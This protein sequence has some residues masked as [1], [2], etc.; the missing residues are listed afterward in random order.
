MQI[1]RAAQAADGSSTTATT[2]G[3]DTGGLSAQW[4]VGPTS[5]SGL[6][7]GL[8]SFE[9]GAATPPHV[10]HV[11]QVL[12]VMSGSGFVEVEGV[13]TALAAGDIVLTPAGEWH[14][15]GA[16][17]DGPMVHLSVTTG[18]NEVRPV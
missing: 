8:I 14:T 5:S 6:D 9:A 11:G 15:H 7:V 18:S 16:G 2:T 13:A 10:H 4:L 12:I 3:T 1:L 17:A